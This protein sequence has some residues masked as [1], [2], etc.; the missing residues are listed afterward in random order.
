MT[1][2]VTMYDAGRLYTLDG[3][4][5]LVTDT[6]KICLLSAAYNPTPT[7]AAWGATTAYALGTVVISSGVY[8]E[9]VT[10]GVSAGSIG[11]FNTTRGALTSDNTVVW[12]S[13]GYAPPS[14]HTVLADIVGSEITATGYTA[15]GVTVT[16]KTLTVAKRQVTYSIA[17]AEWPGFVGTA[18]Y[19]ALYKVGTANGKV[20]PLVCYMLLDSTNAAVTLIEAGKLSLVWTNLG[21]AVFK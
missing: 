9:A 15:G 14:E 11:S 2:D 16:G 12:K 8:Y 5:N 6:L 1:I 21:L 10:A 18:K 4:I 7:A 17:A 13:W 19:A 20:N 3:T